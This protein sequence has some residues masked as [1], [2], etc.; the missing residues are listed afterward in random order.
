MARVLID[1]GWLPQF[2]VFN[3]L[4]LHDGTAAEKES[5]W[6]QRLP[7][8]QARARSAATARSGL[9]A[10]AARLEARRTVPLTL[11]T[12]FAL[13]DRYRCFYAAGMVSPVDGTG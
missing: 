1:S 3:E 11:T 7:P 10:A 9:A 2:K 6:A 8:R 12:H 13:E 4:R 5:A